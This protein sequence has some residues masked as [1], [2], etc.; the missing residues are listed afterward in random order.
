MQVKLFFQAATSDARTYMCL[1]ELHLSKEL[2][3]GSNTFQ[4]KSRHTLG[5]LGMAFILFLVLIILWIMINTWVR[6]IIMVSCTKT[7]A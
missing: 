2:E 3:S 5:I 1:L 6:D 4:T 7:Y